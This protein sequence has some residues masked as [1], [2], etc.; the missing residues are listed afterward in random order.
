MIYAILIFVF[1]WGFLAGHFFGFTAGHRT[2]TFEIISDGIKRRAR[3]TADAMTPEER[4]G[5]LEIFV[6]TLGEKPDGTENE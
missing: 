1:V 3:I 4:A 5:V 2:I 6:T